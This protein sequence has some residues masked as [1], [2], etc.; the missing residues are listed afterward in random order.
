MVRGLR[1]NPELLKLW[2]PALK[3]R[4]TLWWMPRLW[5]AHEERLSGREGRARGGAHVDGLRIIRG[6]TAKLLVLTV[7]RLLDDIER[8]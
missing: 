7:P 3:R 1:V 5:L 2:E 4:H 6:H 8:L